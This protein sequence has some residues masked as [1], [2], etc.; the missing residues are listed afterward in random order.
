MSKKKWVNTLLVSM[1]VMLSVAAAS[2][3]YGDGWKYDEAGK[4]FSY[5]EGE[6]ELPLEEVLKEKKD[7]RGCV[8]IEDGKY[9][10]LNEK[11]EAL[12][13]FRQMEDEKYYYFRED[14]EI[15][16]EML[17]G[18][19]ATGKEKD[20]YGKTQVWWRWFSEKDGKYCRD[21]GSNLRDVSMGVH[22][23]VK[24]H[25]YYI[26][27]ING[28][29]CKNKVSKTTT[30]DYYFSDE[31][32]LVAVDQ[33]RTVGEKTYYFGKNGTMTKG[34]V[35]KEG[36]LYY[37][38]EDYAMARNRGIEHEGVWGKLNENGEWYQTDGFMIEKLKVAEE[39]EQ[40]FLVVSE[41][42]SD[43]NVDISFYSKDANGVWNE[44]F[45]TN[46]FC[47]AMGIGQAHEIISVTPAGVFTMGPIF[48]IKPNPGTS[49]PYTQVDASHYWVGD[50]YSPYYNQF[51]STNEITGFDTNASEHIIDYGDVYNYCI[52]MGYNPNC[53]PHEGSA[54]FIH[55]DNGTPTGGCVSMGEEYMIQL[56]QTLRPGAKTVIGT[57]DMIEQY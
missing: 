1:S 20:Q 13:G 22:S 15:P 33:I 2:M 47:G 30:G 52:D 16:G 11:G 10:A 8:E 49:L 28:Y 55:C 34:W 48:G 6:Q 38:G 57:R 17:M 25:T 3:V 36:K 41:N 9:Y 51:V 43:T 32:G 27:D 35:E 37:F 23:P 54:F 29:V 24:K 21:N 5:L 12:L 53:T 56:I 46:G 50:S 7:E 31:K 14:S 4:V 45:V 39:A 18:G 19:W 40:I 44:I 42:A 26:L